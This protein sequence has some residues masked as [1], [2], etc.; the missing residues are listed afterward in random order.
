MLPTLQIY[1]CGQN[2]DNKELL[3]K[4]IAQAA[5]HNRNTLTGS[6]PDSGFDVFCPNSTVM[7]VA[8]KSCCNKIPLGI[9]CG[10]AAPGVES[11]EGVTNFSRNKGYYVYPRSSTGSKTTLRL[12]NS[13][14]IIDSGY[15]GELMAVF[16]NIGNRE[17]KIEPYQRLLQICAG[18]LGPFLVEVVESL[19]SLGE[20][21]RGSQGFGSTGS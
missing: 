16:D 5:K 14:G 20:T 3:K 11:T 21:N 7:C 9:K 4:Y 1:V 15:R 19:E 10:M 2:S 6:H 12:A 13:V 18:D 17:V 8:E